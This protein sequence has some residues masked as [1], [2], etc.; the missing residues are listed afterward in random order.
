MSDQ[1]RYVSMDMLKHTSCRWM[2]GERYCGADKVH[3]SYCQ[4]HAKLA[5]VP[6]KPKASLDRRR[7][8]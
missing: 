7:Y 6:S 4:P 3:G 1:K 5:Y 2:V 8:P